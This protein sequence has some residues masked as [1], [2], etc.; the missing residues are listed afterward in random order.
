MVGGLLANQHLPSTPIFNL[1]LMH[2]AVFAT[3]PPKRTKSQQM[4]KSFCS[5]SNKTNEK[6]V[7]ENNIFMKIA[8]QGKENAFFCD[9]EVNL[10]KLYSASYERNSAEPLFLRGLESIKLCKIK[11]LGSL[12][13][14]S[15]E[16]PFTA[17][18]H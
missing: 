15:I 8:N 6:Q 9:L 10:V 7:E 17:M 18:H 14:L 16:L 4:W 5:E 12:L 11:L 1:E 3:S 13:K 2:K